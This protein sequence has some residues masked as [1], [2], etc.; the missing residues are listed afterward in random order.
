MDISELFWSA[1][2]LTG[3]SKLIPGVPYII[4]LTEPEDFSIKNISC[5]GAEVIENI[6]KDNLRSIT[7]KSKSTEECN[8][9]VV[10]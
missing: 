3:K 10:Y 5:E 2:T 9:K 1:N 6:I 7:L 8:W 4:L